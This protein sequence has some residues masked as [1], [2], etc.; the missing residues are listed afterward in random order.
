M[1]FR[2]LLLWSRRTRTFDSRAKVGPAKFCWAHLVERTS[3]AVER[4]IT[5]VLTPQQWLV[6]CAQNNTSFIYI[7][8][9][10]PLRSFL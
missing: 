7:I 10:W 8:S 2:P 4:T 6:D 9:K 3:T 1:L 5:A